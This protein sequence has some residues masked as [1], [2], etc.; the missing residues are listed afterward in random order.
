MVVVV[1]VVADVVVD[2][3]DDVAVV[4]VVVDV[5][6]A[7]VVVTLVVVASSVSVVTSS[8][9]YGAVVASS[10]GPK[11][12]NA[13]LITTPSAPSLDT[14]TNTVPTLRARTRPMRPKRSPSILTAS[15]CGTKRWSTENTSSRAKRESWT[16]TLVFEACEM[17]ATHVA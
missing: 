10:K 13:S 17:P 7:V 1:V 15:P 12:R 5:F 16:R 2:V 3:D 4:D 11:S 14:T 6:V 8:V 9:V